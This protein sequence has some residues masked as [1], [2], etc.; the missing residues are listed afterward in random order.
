M[1]TSLRYLTL[2]VGRRASVGLGFRVRLL[3]FRVRV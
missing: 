2:D 1:L 3:G